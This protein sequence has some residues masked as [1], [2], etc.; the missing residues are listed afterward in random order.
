MLFVKLD[1][2]KKANHSVAEDVLLP[3]APT[4]SATSLSLAV[5]GVFWQVVQ[6]H[7]RDISIFLPWNFRVLL[8][9]LAVGVQ[10]Y[11]RECKVLFVGLGLSLAK[12]VSRIPQA[13]DW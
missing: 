3:F 9:H 8:F 6:C 7:F 2:Q 12:D 11:R 13:E 1:H 10:P 4:N 5:L